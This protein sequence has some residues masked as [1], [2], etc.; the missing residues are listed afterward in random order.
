MAQVCFR[1]GA[2]AISRDTCS[3][4]CEVVEVEADC[5][6]DASDLGGRMRRR[7]D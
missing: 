7:E 4:G 1:K 5:L 2:V 6:I 3:R